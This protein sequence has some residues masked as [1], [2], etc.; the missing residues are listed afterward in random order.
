[1]RYNSTRT[2]ND[3]GRESRSAG[4]PYSVFRIPYSLFPIPTYLSTAYAHPESYKCYNL[5]SRRKVARR[6]SSLGISATIA[7]SE[8][9]AL[10]SCKKKAHS[11][12][13][14]Q[15]VPSPLVPLVRGGDDGGD[16][17]DASDGSDD[18]SEASNAS[19]GI[20]A[21]AESPECHRRG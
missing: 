10:S 7:T 16:G 15:V 13:G 14:R 18:G 11:R 17:G 1:M 2:V 5:Q 9:C 6:I 12:A 21:D 4:G 20:G 19:D 3:N 8:P